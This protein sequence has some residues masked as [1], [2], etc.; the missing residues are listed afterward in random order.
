MEMQMRIA[1]YHIGMLL[2]IVLYLCSYD[3]VS[4]MLPQAPRLVCHI[5]TAIERVENAVKPL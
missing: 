2:V 3:A 4:D 1:I 5:F